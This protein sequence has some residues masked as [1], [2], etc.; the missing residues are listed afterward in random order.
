[1]SLR[2]SSFMYSNES[3]G[4]ST[5]WTPTLS[6]VHN[7][8]KSKQVASNLGREEYQGLF[9]LAASKVAPLFGD[10]NPRVSMDMRR[11]SMVGSDA[12]KK[13]EKK[14]WRIRESHEKL[15]LM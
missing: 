4:I 14:T 9:L 11:I 2:L 8:K 1:M 7:A 3:P 10:M 12:A 5:W 13:T 15:C 6:H